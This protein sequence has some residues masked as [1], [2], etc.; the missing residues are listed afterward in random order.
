MER[1]KRVMFVG[2]GSG[3]G[4]TTITCAL[5]KALRETGEQVV[6]FKCGPDYID[7]MFHCHITGVPS[8]N[9]DSFFL[10]KETLCWL[11]DRRLFE[12]SFGIVEG[13]M[14]AFDGLGMSVRGSSFEIALWTQTPMVLIVN[15]RGMSMSVV[16]LIL[17]FA[18][19]A[20]S[21][22]GKGLLRGVILNQ[23]SQ[24]TCEFLRPQIETHTGL[25]VLGYFP[26]QE[27]GGLKSR[28]LGLVTAAEVEDLDERMN[29]LARMAA[30]SIDLNGIRAIA[31]S[32]GSLQKFQPSFMKAIQN[33]TGN[34]ALPTEV[35]ESGGNVKKS[36]QKRLRPA[37][38]LAIAMDKAFCFY[39]NENLEL[40]NMLGVELKPFSPLAE[41]LP[42]RICGLYLGGGYPELFARE[43]SLNRGLLESI[44]QACA[45]GLPVIAECGGFMYLHEMLEGF[46][47]AGVIPGKAYMT[48][49]LGPFGYIKVRSK[50]KSVFGPENTSFLGH[51]FHYS[52]SDTCGG[53][54]IVSKANGRCWEEGFSSPSMYAGYP[55]LYF[56]SNVPA[57]IHF[58]QAMR[59]FE[60]LNG[61]GLDDGAAN[62][63]HMGG[64]L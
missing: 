37:L 61:S 43:L 33:F 32:A 54:F 57:V 17:G 42:E 52:R 48:K 1:K 24:S 39:Y 13:V 12:E 30:S 50:A 9:L 16:A 36:A 55:H 7:P 59:D 40:L 49:K 26:K 11:M 18:Q 58:V 3:C 4:K 35:L 34:I 63:G 41:P 23:I 8:T 38:R 53:S 51:E 44:K 29:V 47:M 19:F 22:G 20:E 2:T 10:D 62:L 27:D 25:K 28:H 60:K 5:M 64:K 45:K 31:S 14:G 46:K 56:Y 21:F 6:P 15:A